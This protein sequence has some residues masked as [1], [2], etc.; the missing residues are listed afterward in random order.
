MTEIPKLEVKTGYEIL[1]EL[2]ELHDNPKGM[3][4]PAIR[5]ITQKKWVSSE[6]VRVLAAAL[7]KKLAHPNGYGVLGFC[8]DCHKTI[9]TCKCP[10]GEVR[11]ELERV[12]GEKP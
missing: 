10:T 8:N 7:A 12:G 2:V 11:R 9:A 3:S 6:S 4:L 5:A 1:C